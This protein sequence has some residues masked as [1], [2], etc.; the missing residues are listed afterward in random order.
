[1]IKL[2]DYVETGLALGGC[3]QLNGAGPPQ[4]MSLIKKL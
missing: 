2:T 1:M 3:K 4:G